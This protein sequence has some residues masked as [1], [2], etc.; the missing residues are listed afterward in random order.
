VSAKPPESVGA[1]AVKDVSELVS[2]YESSPV[3]IVAKLRRID[4]RMREHDDS[5]CWKGRRVSVHVVDVVGNDEIHFAFRRL[6][7]SAQLGKRSLGCNGSPLS[8]ILE[9]A[10][11]MHVE[12]PGL[13]RVPL[14][15]RH[16]LRAR[17]V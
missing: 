5:V 14:V 1:V 9:T 6:E 16:E 10:R 4:R 7:L 15:A 17:A 8:F 13:D 3:G 12:V 2:Y 11:I